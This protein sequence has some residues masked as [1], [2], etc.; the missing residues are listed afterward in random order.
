MATKKHRVLVAEDNPALAAVIRF[1]LEKAGIEVEVSLTGLA[2][3]EALAE[4]DFDLLLTDHQMPRMTGVELCKRIRGDERLRDLPVVFCTAKGL[5]ID[6]DSLMAE[7]GVLDVIHKP[8][9][10][11]G[12]CRIVEDIVANDG[13]VNR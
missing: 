4:S 7:L 13:V 5:E 9:S 11:A 12:L 10:P 2:A 8:F 3:W 1:N 6:D